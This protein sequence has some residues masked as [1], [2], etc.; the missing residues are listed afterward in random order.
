[1]VLFA[2]NVNDFSPLTAFVQISISDVW[3]GSEYLSADSK[4]IVNFLKKPSSWLIR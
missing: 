3:L 2:K 4:A 1:M